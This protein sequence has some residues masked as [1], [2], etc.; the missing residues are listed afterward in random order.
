MCPSYKQLVPLLRTKSARR[1]A[2]SMKT[3]CLYIYT[4]IFVLQKI[5]S[6]NKYNQS[7][8]QPALFI[9]ETDNP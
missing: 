6:T 8:N 1:G 2:H 3:Y 4:Y 9:I 7:T 5:T